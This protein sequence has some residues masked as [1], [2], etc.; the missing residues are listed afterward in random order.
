MK[1]VKIPLINGLGHTKGCEKAPDLLVDVLKKR[2]GM[3]PFVSDFNISKM[4]IEEANKEILNKS[5]EFFKSGER[6]LFLGGDHSISY[7][8][9]KG[10]NQVINKKE[11][12]ACLII[13]D[14]HLD[15]MPVSKGAEDYPTHEEWLRGIIDSGFAIKN[16]LLVGIRNFYSVERDFAKKRGIKI[17]KMKPFV[18]DLSDACDT[19]MEF[20]NNKELYLSID[21]DVVDPVFAPGTGYKEIGGLSSKE[22][23]FII[24][25]LRKMKNLRAIDL[26]EIN[27]ERDVDNLTLNLG[28]S[29]LDV[30]YNGN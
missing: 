4:N 30:F 14:A 9:V 17:M 2:T 22:F 8:L 3:K 5:N 13:F 27:P 16:I 28:V 12:Q 7:S 1:I 10:F 18:E 29:I 15:L 26:V 23:L 19:I 24:S 21:I 20:A 25:R 11:K 6:I